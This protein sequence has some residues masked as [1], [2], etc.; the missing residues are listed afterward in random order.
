MIQ[1]TTISGKKIPKA[2]RWTP[3]ALKNGAPMTW[4]V[5]LNGDIFSHVGTLPPLQKV[6]P[7]YGYSH[8]CVRM[9]PADAKHVFQFL[10]TGDRVT[11]QD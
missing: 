5:Q 11:V 6:L 8:G 4:A 10:K 9:S 2:Q 3:Q 7:D 1:F